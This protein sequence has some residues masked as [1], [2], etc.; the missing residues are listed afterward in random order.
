[1][2]QDRQHPAGRFVTA[3]WLTTRPLGYVT[4]SLGPNTVHPD[5]CTSPTHLTCCCCAPV[6]GRGASGWKRPRPTEKG[7]Q[8]SNNRTASSGLSAVT[9]HRRAGCTRTSLQGTLAISPSDGT[10]VPRGP[11]VSTFTA[12][13]LRPAAHHPSPNRTTSTFNPKSLTHDPQGTSHSH[14]SDFNSPGSHF[15]EHGV[16]TVSAASP[17]RPQHSSGEVRRR[18]NRRGRPEENPAP[19][20]RRD[21][22]SLAKV[23]RLW[24]FGY[25]CV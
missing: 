8:A 22:R 14:L 9:R 20:V 11:C 5:L 10:L 19:R 7:A 1:M 12:H 3:G 18:Q 23:L 16:T 4:C 17:C 24:L 25:R 2:D 6:L 21:G 15:F 13:P